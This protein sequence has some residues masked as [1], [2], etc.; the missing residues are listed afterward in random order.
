MKGGYRKGAGRKKGYAA[1]EAEKARELIAEQLS[2][3]LEPI[4]KKAIKQARAGDK[5]ARAWLFERAY[6][7][8]KE[9]VDMSVNNPIPILTN[10][11][12]EMI[13]KRIL[14]KNT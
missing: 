8:P 13:A 7:K 6:G 10:L 1:F 9:I 11:Q 4:I 12:K 2:V 14:N 3:E 5:H